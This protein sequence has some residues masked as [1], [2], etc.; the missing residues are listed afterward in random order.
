LFRERDEPLCQEVTQPRSNSVE[1]RASRC[2]VDLATPVVEAIRSEARCRFTGKIPN[3]T[4]EV[5]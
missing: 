2:G 4:I 3:G 5:R 1:G